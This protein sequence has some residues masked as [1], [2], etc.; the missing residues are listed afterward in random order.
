[1][2]II[3]DCEDCDI[4]VCDYTAQVQIDYNKNCRIF[5]GPSESSVSSC[6]CTSC[7]HARTSTRKHARPHT[8]TRMHTDV[9]RNMGTLVLTE[10][11]VMWR[12]Y[13]SATAPTASA[14]SRANNIVR[15]SARTATRCSLPQPHL[16]SS[17][18]R[19]C[20]SGASASFTSISPINSRPSKCQCMTISGV[21]CT[22]LRPV[23]SRIF[24]SYR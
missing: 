14:S 3:E 11:L 1:M 21:K 24:L 10:V 9:G 4:Y 5:V 6:V 15:A 8:P 20:V 12:R 19:T 13:L 17:H 22:I 18:R 7:T 2:F 23:P 16:S